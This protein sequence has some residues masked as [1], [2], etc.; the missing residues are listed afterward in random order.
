MLKQY[1]VSM[2]Y[3]DDVVRVNVDMLGPLYVVPGPIVLYSI[4]S[5]YVG[6]KEA[7][8]TP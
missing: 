4:Q 3:T 6:Y 1:K 8:G 7:V 2:G 5:T